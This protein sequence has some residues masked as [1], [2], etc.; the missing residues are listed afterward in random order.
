MESAVLGNNWNT[1]E[2]ETLCFG[3]IF[4]F[5]SRLSHKLKRKS[6][7]NMSALK[8]TLSQ[9]MIW[10]GNEGYS[11][12]LNL[13]IYFYISV[14]LFFIFLYFLRDIDKFCK[15]ALYRDHPKNIWCFIKRS[16]NDHAGQRLV[17]LKKAK[18]VANSH[19]TA[20]MHAL[21]A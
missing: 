6:R 13:N 1:Q 8:R 12:D 14:F 2:K 15:S 7:L 5:L 10:H 20:L 17:A 19:Y 4:A 16:V 3:R 21:I 9:G 18:R 11:K